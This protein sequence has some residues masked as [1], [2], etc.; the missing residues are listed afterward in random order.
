MPFIWTM[1]LREYQIIKSLATTLSIMT[2][3][4]LSDSGTPS[5][6]ENYIAQTMFQA[7]CKCKSCCQSRCTSW[8]IFS[9]GSADVYKTHSLVATIVVSN[10]NNGFDTYITEAA[11][12][13]D[14]HKKL[15]VYA[16]GVPTFE[17]SVPTQAHTPVLWIHQGKVVMGCSG[18][19][20]IYL[21][22]RAGQL[23]QSIEHGKEGIT[24]IT[25]SGLY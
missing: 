5:P 8:S 24:D 18:Q 7:E 15:A 1:D 11:V 16:S 21:W 22:D 17:C 12:D 3:A 25:A 13:S 20:V 6:A 23:L 19:G 9:S 4:I 14:L 2:Y 10:L